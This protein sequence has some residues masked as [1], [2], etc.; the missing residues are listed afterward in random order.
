MPGIQFTAGESWRATYS[1]IYSPQFIA[2]FLA[3]AYSTDHL[4]RSVRSQRTTFLVAKEDDVAVVGFCHFGPSM[5]DA[6]VQLY[7]LYVD[8]DY[9]RLGIGGRLVAMMEAHLR[10]QGAAEYFCYVHARNTLG[11]AFYLKYGF[12]H[13]EARDQRNGEEWCMVKALG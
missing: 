10:G 13:V 11:Q 5:D 8:P 2:D 9:W 6:G 4:L 1:G 3:D 12:V 7:R